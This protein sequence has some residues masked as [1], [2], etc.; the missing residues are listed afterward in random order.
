MHQHVEGTGV[1]LFMIKR[2][3]ENSGGRIEMKSEE[4]KGTEF[5]VYLSK[6]ADK[7]E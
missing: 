3:I 6:V 2:V 5:T 7:K 4:G 1:G